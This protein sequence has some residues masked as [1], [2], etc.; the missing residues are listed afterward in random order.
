MIVDTVVL[1]TDRCNYIL[2]NII[3]WILFGHNP[4]SKSQEDGDEAEAFWLDG[5]IYRSTG[6]AHLFGLSEDMKVSPGKLRPDNCET[7][8]LLCL[9]RREIIE[10]TYNTG[11]WLPGN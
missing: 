4:D 9:W 8:W 2:G 10:H 7:I 6:P 5:Y 11:G 3:I 1:K